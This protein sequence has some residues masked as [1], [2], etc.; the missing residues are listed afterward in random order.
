MTHNTSTPLWLNLK[1]NYIDENFENVINYIYQNNTIRKDEFYGITINL[2]ERR[3]DALIEEFHDQPLLYDDYLTQDKER[4]KFT[5]QL[6]GLYLL[7][8][9]N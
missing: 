6:L 8:V 5:A 3:I 1:V 2:L 4:A 9:S 7:S